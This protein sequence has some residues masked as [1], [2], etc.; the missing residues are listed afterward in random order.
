MCGSSAR[1][2]RHAW[3]RRD[4]DALRAIGI[5]L[6][7]VRRMA[8]ESFGPG[9]LDRAPRP[10]GPGMRFTPKAKQVGAEVLRSLGV[11]PAMVRARVLE[12]VSRAS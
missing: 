3:A 7:E 12:K 9:A 10:C 1:D 4:A 8:E 6:D 2:R 5:D 11:D